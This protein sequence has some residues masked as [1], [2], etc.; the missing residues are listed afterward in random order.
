MTVDALQF[1]ANGFHALTG[2]KPL[3]WQR[4]LFLEHFVRSDLPP[5]VD[6]P[7]GLGKTSVIAIWLLALAHQS[8]TNSVPLP[9]RLLYVV[10]RRTVVDQATDLVMSMRAAVATAGEGSDT[11]RQEIRRALGELC[12]DPSDEASPLAVSTLRGEL[13]DNRE[14][15]SDPARPTIIIGTVDMIGSR[16]LFSG[17]GVSRRMRPF[18]AGL[19]GQDTLIVHDEAHLT[20]AFSRLGLCIGEIQSGQPRPIR[21]I[22]LSATRRQA[23]PVNAFALTPEEEK[24]EEVERRLSADKRLRFHPLSAAGKLP[25]KLA[26]LA[27]AHQS[28]N[29][30]VVVYVRSPATAARVADLVAKTA[31]ADQVVTLTGTIRGYE[32]DLLAPNQLDTVTDAARRRRAELFCGFRAHPDRQPPKRSEYLV[33]TSAGEVGVDLDADH[34]I[35]DVSTLDSMIQRLG[36]VNRLG[37]G[38]ALIDVVEILAKTD[39]DDEESGTDGLA[40]LTRTVEALKSLPEIDGGTNASPRALRSLAGKGEAFSRAPRTLPLTDILLDGWAMTRVAELPGRPHVE[41]WLHGV[42][43]SPPELHVAWRQELREIKDPTASILK[44]LFDRH[45]I[46]ARERLRGNLK[47]VVGELKKVAKRSEDAVLLPAIGD[48]RMIALADIDQG[49]AVLRDG[50][51]VLRSDAG[52]LDEHGMLDGGRSSSVPDVAD[53]PDTGKDAVRRRLRILLEQNEDTGDWIA[54]PLAPPDMWDFA[55]TVLQAGDLR[56][57]VGDLR[58]KL[59]QVGMVEKARLVLAKGEEGEPAKIL[60]FFALRKSVEVAQDSPAAAARWQ[61]LEEHLDWTGCEAERLVTKLKLAA[62]S[63]AI[64]DAIVVA[65]RWHDRGK[66]RAAWQ[67]AIGHA[68]DNS[69]DWK[70]W[71]KSGERGFDDSACGRYRHEFGSLREAMDDQKIRDHSERDLILHLVSAHH[72]WARPHF[73]PEHWDI[74]D[75]VTEEENASIAADTMRRF[76]QLQRRFGHW[77]LAW[78]ES[79][80]RSADYA[81]TKRL[82]ADSGS[83]RKAAS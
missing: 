83:F 14:W 12:V 29:A 2:H 74:A 1:F 68:P 34:M 45:P 11:I 13:A 15:Q 40:R 65:A 78:L 61:E 51:I 4:R 16:L 77:G 46:L 81:A 23:E 42:Q 75:D 17:Y 19:L 9:R 43:A 6:I 64:A 41:R 54:R 82:S 21:M 31:G 72:G 49:D 35:C 22:E 60:L 30:R 44:T 36:R 27:L 37:R 38:A 67:K 70:P 33:C 50:T 39:E 47:D 10:N 5:A 32:R 53:E 55:G 76:A 24:E 80:M 57:A 25:E 18:H 62:L 20:P 63:P 8:A 3:G 69:S 71:A 66:D 26:E 48:P 59:R 7:T 56:A 58:E 52:G 79:L 73:E 28:A